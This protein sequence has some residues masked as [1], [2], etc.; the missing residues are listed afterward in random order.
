MPP[1]TTDE[2]TKPVFHPA[3][4]VNNIKNSIPLTLDRNDDRYSSWVELFQ[5]HARAFNVL[6]HID[7]T[8]PK[9]TDI[10]SATWDQ[11]DAIVKQWIYSTISQELIH[12]IMKPGA[13]AFQLW[14]RLKEI[15]QDNAATRAVYLE[16]L[17]NSTRLEA[18]SSVTEYCDRLKALSDQ[19]TNVGNPISDTKMVLQLV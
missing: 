6:D 13:T 1:A 3:F 18:F 11:L 10:D 17:F 2:V 9:T 4:T 19:L 8:H 14:S 12:A 15:F 7:K 5:I 16:E